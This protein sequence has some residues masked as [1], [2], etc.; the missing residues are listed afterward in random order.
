[1]YVP[2]APIQVL[3]RSFS[4]IYATGVTADL[5]VAVSTNRGRFETTI[6]NNYRLKNNYLN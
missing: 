3:R 1:M 2:G 6:E 4:R 5:N